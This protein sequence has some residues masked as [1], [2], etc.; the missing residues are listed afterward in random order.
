MICPI[1]TFNNVCKMQC[2][3]HVTVLADFQHP[4]FAS[5]ILCIQFILNLHDIHQIYPT[6]SC[7]TG[8]FPITVYNY[9]QLHLQVLAEKDFSSNKCF[10]QIYVIVINEP[11]Y[12]QEM[13]TIPQQVQRDQLATMTKQVLQ[14]SLRKIPK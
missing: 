8:C 11:F 13:M 7:M 14:V 2:V 3:V 12:V 9:M 5:H 6:M 10:D 1:S 4:C